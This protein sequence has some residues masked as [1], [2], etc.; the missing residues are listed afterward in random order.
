MNQHT[1][2]SPRSQ[3]TN[4]RAPQIP[5]GLRSTFM[6]TTS[7]G[8]FEGASESNQ[9]LRI[10]YHVFDYLYTSQP[11]FRDF[12]SQ[13]EREYRLRQT[14]ISPVGTADPNDGFQG[15]NNGSPRVE[16]HHN[17]PFQVYSDAPPPSPTFSHPP[18]PP[19][20]QSSRSPAQA[21]HFD[22]GYFTVRSAARQLRFDD[23]EYYE[24]EYEQAD[25]EEDIIGSPFLDPDTDYDDGETRLRQLAEVA[26]TH[27]PIHV[28]TFH[29]PSP[30]STSATIQ[31]PAPGIV[32]SVINSVVQQGSEDGTIE[33]RVS[34]P[35]S[36]LP[37]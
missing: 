21:R 31:A 16:H 22:D 12:V 2:Y 28:L 18:S 7:R 1:R 10:L 27:G 8:P 6:G 33:I 36:R 9:D 29:Y 13:R 30:A 23:A 25:D 11:G 32:S 5:G 14:T 15:V 3:H 35:V 26:V 34:V 17:P 4:S 19:Q 20:A 37:N 24:D